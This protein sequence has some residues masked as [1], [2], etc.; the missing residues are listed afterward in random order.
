[1]VDLRYRL[2]EQFREVARAQQEVR[3]ERLEVV[4][5][6]ELVVKRFQEAVAR[7]RVGV[8]NRA[9]EPG[10]VAV[11]EGCIS[12]DFAR[13]TS[14]GVWL[15]LRFDPLG[16]VAAVP[17]KVETSARGKDLISSIICMLTFFPNS[18]DTKP[19]T[20][21]LTEMYFFSHTLPASSPAPPASIPPSKPRS[22]APPV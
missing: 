5:Q 2:H 3:L 15:C 17:D 20:M 12:F 4:E 7:E 6:F 21:F 13:P 22:P 11:F 14:T 19:G 18:S 16:V 1:M 8:V 9:L 10:Q